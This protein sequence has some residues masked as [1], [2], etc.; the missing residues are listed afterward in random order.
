MLEQ[1]R[2]WAV[3]ALLATFAAGGLFG[4]AVGTRVHAGPRG[5]AFR[6]GGPGPD[7]MIGFLSERLDLTAGQRDSGRAI[8]GRHRAGG[9]EIWREGHPRVE[10]VRSAVSD[11]VH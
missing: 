6:G 11:G 8:L 10:L 2:F 9:G 7:G 4:W 5:G 1:S 3:A